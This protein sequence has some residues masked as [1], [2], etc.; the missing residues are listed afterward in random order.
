MKSIKMIIV[1]AQLAGA[2]LILGLLLFR[3]Y[4][5]EQKILELEARVERLER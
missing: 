5:S 2:I 4:Q 1:I 3:D